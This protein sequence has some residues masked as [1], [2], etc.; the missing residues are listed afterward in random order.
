MHITERSSGYD[1]CIVYLD[2][3]PIKDFKWANDETGEVMVVS[4]NHTRELRRGNVKIVLNAGS[5]RF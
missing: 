5:S 4:R 1:D 2:G 3:T